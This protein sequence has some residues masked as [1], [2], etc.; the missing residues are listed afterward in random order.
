M[1]GLCA[2]VIHEIYNPARDLLR[3]TGDDDPAGGVL[4]GARDKVVFG[5]RRRREK[6]ETPEPV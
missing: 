5:G 3:Q 2:L 6:V 1:I 4:D